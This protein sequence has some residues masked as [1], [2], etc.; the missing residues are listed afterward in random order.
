MFGPVQTAGDQ[1][2]GGGVHQMNH[3]LETEGKPWATIPAKTGVKCFQMAEDGIEEVLGH[4]GGAF[5]VGG[6]EGVLAGRG[7]AA[8]RREWSR[9]QTQGV[10]DIVEADGVGE[11][12]VE[13]AHHMTP[14][15]KRAGAFDHTSIPREF[16]HQMRRNKIAELLQEREA[17]ARWL[18]RC[19]FI[20]PLPCGRFT[21]RKPTLFYPST[22]KPV[23]RLC[24]DYNS[25]CFH[26]GG[27]FAC[28]GCGGG[29]LL[30]GNDGCQTTIKR[31]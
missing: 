29:G 22:L 20:H 3:P 17:A 26:Q 19:G 5:A 23:G 12:G 10:A 27:W 25:F 4:L 1:L 7:R 18:V 2:N 24:I 28:V 30:G 6:R 14:R 13:Q 31:K 16:G 9:M 8:H 11:L 15:R 21:R